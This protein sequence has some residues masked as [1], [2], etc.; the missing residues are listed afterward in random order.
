[1]GALDHSCNDIVARVTDWPFELQEDLCRDEYRRPLPTAQVEHSGPHPRSDTV[2]RIL[3]GV[4]LEGG[5]ISRPR[6]AT[7][8]P[9][10]H[11]RHHRS[12]TDQD[13][14]GLEIGMDHV[15]CLSRWWDVATHEP[16]ALDQGRHHGGIPRKPGHSPRQTRS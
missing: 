8:V 4:P 3:E 15:R 13:I 7:Y 12:I 6:A 9:D 1:M 16:Q 11:D 5:E 14:V 10:T 2:Q